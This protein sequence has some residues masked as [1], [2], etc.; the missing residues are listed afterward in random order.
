M[1]NQKSF[2]KNLTFCL[3][4]FFAFTASAQQE[5]REQIVVDGIKREFVVYTP[6]ATIAANKI[7]V[8]ITLHGRLG[9]GQQMVGFA[10]FR[11]IAYREK[12]IIISPDGINKSW[13]DG[14]ETPAHKKGIDDVKFIN[15]LID[16]ALNTYNGDPA[17]VYVTGMSNGGF[18][19][20]RL[21]CELSN[22]IAAIAIV[23]ASMDKDM[24]YHPVKG[25]PIMYIQGT[26][27]PLV[28][29]N[30]GTMKGAG[31]EI[32]SHVDVLKLWAD[33]AHCNDK[34]TITSLPDV[35][36]DGTSVIKEE[37]SNPGNGIKVVGY[38]ITNGGHTWPGGTQYLPKFMIGPLSHNLNACDVIWEFFKGYVK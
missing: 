2:L 14:R 11:S 20:S 23:G 1:I 19:S 9:N 8:L 16:Y 27:D 26:K 17:R 38:T 37:Y 15:Q 13:N 22:R 28:P 35:A 3:F 21:A 30:G 34:P 6:S 18:M 29:Y 4:A 31:G 24:D 25:I 32:Y 12:F 33:A 5:K 36:H 7:P 10:D